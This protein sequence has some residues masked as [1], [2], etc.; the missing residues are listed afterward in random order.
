MSNVLI[1]RPQFDTKSLKPGTAVRVKSSD[2]NNWYG[3]NYD[4]LIVE[5][6][7]LSLKLAYVKKSDKHMEDINDVETKSLPV[8]MVA[9]GVITIEKL[10]VPKNVQE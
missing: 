5:S 8:D 7:P 9:D 6:R 1:E 4:C 3:F 10:E 2:R